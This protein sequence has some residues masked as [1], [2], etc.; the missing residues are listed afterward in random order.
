MFKDRLGIILL[1]ICMVIAMSLV[2][3]NSMFA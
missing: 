1:G 3:Y 2:F